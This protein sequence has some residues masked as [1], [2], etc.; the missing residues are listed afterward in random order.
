MH[1]YLASLSGEKL[2]YAIEI[3]KN[4]FK[5]ILKIK[6]SVILKANK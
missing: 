5:K 6:N 3:E 1:P 2:E 4:I